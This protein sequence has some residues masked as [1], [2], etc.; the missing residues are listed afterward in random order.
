MLALVS[1]TDTLRSF[2]SIPDFLFVSP[3]RT[4]Y[5][6]GP[7]FF[8]WGGWEGINAEDICAQLTLVPAAVWT[9][10][11]QNCAALLER[12]FSTFLVSVFGAAYFFVVYKVISYVY[13]R[14]FVLAPIISE[15]RRCLPDLLRGGAIE[16]EGRETQKSE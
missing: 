3:L 6:H 16:C 1:L 8:G 2:K 15:L 9:D 10:Q 12:K 13:F 4:L 11:M 7:R 14:Y 5:F